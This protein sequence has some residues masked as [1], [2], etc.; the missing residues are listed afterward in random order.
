[1]VWRETE[2]LSSVWRE[3]EALSRVWRETEALSR[4][5]RETEALSSVWR[6]TEVLSSVWRYCCSWLS[7]RLEL[8]GGLITFFAAL[9]AVLNRD[10]VDPALVGLSISS[11]LQLKA[12]ACYTS[13]NSPLGARQTSCTPGGKIVFRF[14]SFSSA[15]RAEAR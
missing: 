15:F 11:S 6:E 1:S 8:I 4:V 2:V 7:V 5:W 10:T 9:F 14:R 3:T 13:F 12:E